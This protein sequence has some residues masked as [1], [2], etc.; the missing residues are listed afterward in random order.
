[1]FTAKGLLITTLVLFGD[2]NADQARVDL[3]DHQAV[4]REGSQAGGLP[5]GRRR[6]LIR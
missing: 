2:A 3:G 4:V 1:M 6:M 5:V